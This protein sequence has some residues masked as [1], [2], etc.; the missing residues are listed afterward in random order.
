MMYKFKYKDV[1]IRWD[2]SS[3]QIANSKIN[4]KFDLTGGFPRT[5]SL[6]DGGGNEF[7]D[8]NKSDCDGSFIGLNRPGFENSEYQNLGI[9]AVSCPATLF[10]AELV[11]ITVEIFEQVQQISWRR[12]YF[13]YP[14]FPAIAV[15]NSIQT[16]VTPL[17]YYQYRRDDA[18]DAN[19]R[20]PI[21]HLESCADS[22]KLN[23]EFNV[24]HSVEFRGRTDTFDHLVIKHNHSANL[25]RGN[26]LLCENSRNQGCLLLQEAPPS[27]ER[28]D[29][30]QYDFR[31]NDTEI[32]SCNWGI[33]PEELT[34]EQR[35]VGY[36]HVIMLFDG[37]KSS[38]MQLKQY[39]K[40]RFP[41]NIDNN[42]SIMVNPWGCGRFA[43]SLSEEFLIA[44]VAASSA[45]G[46]THYQIDDNWQ[47]GGNLGEM[48]I[49]NRH[50]TPKYWQVGATV[51]GSFE[52][53]T[54]HAKDKMIE[55]A[56][57]IAPSS[58]C[59]YR[60]WHTIAEIIFDFHTRYGFNIFKID[61]MMIRTYEAEDNLRQMLESL[62]IRS[63]GKI[64]FNLDTT[65]GQRPG[66]FMFLEYGNIFLENRYVCHNWGVGYHPEQTLRNL[67][68]LAQY[69]RPQTLQIEIP[70]PSDINPQF[71][72]ER[73]KSL[74]N[75]YAYE[76][77]LAIAMFA[78]PLLWFAPSRISP[79]LQAI[80]AKMMQL[81]QQHRKNIFAGEIF[82]IGQQPN[83]KAI[84]GFYSTSGYLI[85][86]RELMAKAKAK[87]IL[88]MELN[89]ITVELLY[90]NADKPQLQFKNDHNL[91]VTMPEAASFALWKINTK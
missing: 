62:R 84:T 8:A 17:M 25:L 63:Q 16:P 61:A 4:R 64:Y 27:S 22:I 47:A 26:L 57:W 15:T 32:Y 49:K 72:L 91:S 41:M 21:D 66:Y 70:S 13:I 81:H 80:T 14:D 45:C 12:V 6:Q 60:D 53:I 75:V 86:Y 1:I 43:R 46:A 82:S 50:I 18:M 51:G 90:S 3:L 28:R 40:R 77:W 37:K 74:P 24:T 55:L 85:V 42:C 83:G 23:P 10:D 52:K 39:L 20:F 31:I 35:F 54:Q 76:Y 56:L 44:E 73:K 79:E 34:P 29:F 5:I 71:Y 30:E 11:Q 58:N 89:N 33:P 48:A 59:E 87:I 69:I 2:E 65:N 68:Q 9:T 7:A 19:K 67:W 38:N 78:N 88:P 36:R